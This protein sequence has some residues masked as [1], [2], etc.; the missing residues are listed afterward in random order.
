MR[1]SYRAEYRLKQL[2]EEIEKYEKE[3]VVLQ[4]QNV[5]VHESDFRVLRIEANKEA[6]VAIIRNLF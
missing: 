1:K 5:Y 2:I 3:I 6:I 4:N